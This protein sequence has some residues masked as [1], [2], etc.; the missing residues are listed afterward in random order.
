MKIKADMAITNKWVTSV[1]ITRKA[2]LTPYL[3]A[4]NVRT[5]QGP[6]CLG[7]DDRRSTSLRS[8]SSPSVLIVVNVASPL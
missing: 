7:E 4:S 1:F 2:Q 6:F 8:T 3:T 5:K